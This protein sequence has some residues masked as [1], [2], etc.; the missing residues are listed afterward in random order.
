VNELLTNFHFI[1]PAWL[2]ALLPLAYIAWRLRQQ[3]NAASQFHGII[4]PHLVEHLIAKPKTQS[5]LQPLHLFVAACLIMIIALAGPTWKRE[6]LPFTEDQ[7]PLVIALD[8]SES[9]NT[10]DVQPSRLERAKQKIRD[11]L[12]LR[13]GARSGLVV[14]AG[15]AHVVLPLTDDP[16]ILTTYLESISSEIMPVPGKDASAALR[17]AEQMLAPETVAGTILY[18][19]DRIDTD[20]AHA[21]SDFQKQNDHAVLGLNISY[22]DMANITGIRWTAMTAD[23]TDVKRVNR[24]IQSHMQAM[25]NE[26]NNQR[27]QDK[28][29]WLAWPVAGLMLFWFRRGWSISW[30]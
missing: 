21:I 3:Q 11:L 30:D 29:Y 18:V 17:A 1:R 28:G 4:A 20:P 5:R 13:A 7:A 6:P 10:R 15:S 8:L 27:W 12:A 26:D 23:D 25:E 2:L 22:Q 9:M 16:N 19:T 14:Y 24:R